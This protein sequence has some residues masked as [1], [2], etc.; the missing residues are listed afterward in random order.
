MM[1][2]DDAWGELYPNWSVYF[3][4]DDIDA[5]TQKAK[6]LGG[7]VHVEKRAAGEMG[8]FSVVGDPQGAIFTMIQFNGPV[9][10]PPGH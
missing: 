7:A 3:M 9:D 2:W 10:A 5:S 1:Q 4:V 8:V 6:S